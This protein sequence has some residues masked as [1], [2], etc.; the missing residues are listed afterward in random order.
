[1]RFQNFNEKAKFDFLW[2]FKYQVL[3]N[4]VT[5][6]NFLYTSQLI[7]NICLTSENWISPTLFL[8]V[9]HL[10]HIQLNVRSYLIVFI[11]ASFTQI[12]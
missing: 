7:N 4:F 6:A 9:F 3:T 10:A 1:M 11:L 2:L 12:Y 5:P 8:S